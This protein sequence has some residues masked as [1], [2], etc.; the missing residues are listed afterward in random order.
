MMVSRHPSQPLVGAGVFG[1]ASLTRPAHEALARAA[2]PCLTAATPRQPA[3]SYEAARGGSE[4]RGGSGRQWGPPSTHSLVPNDVGA[5]GSRTPRRLAAWPGSY[6]S[7]PHLSLPSRA[8]SRC[9][10]TCESTLPAGRGAC[11][12]ALSRRRAV[13]RARMRTAEG[14]AGNSRFFHAASARWRAAHAPWAC[15]R[16]RGW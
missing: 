4:P 1:P 10:G 14:A 3:G 15:S 13:G 2:A 9:S 16:H 12:H 8:A 6:M 7:W 5:R 11:R